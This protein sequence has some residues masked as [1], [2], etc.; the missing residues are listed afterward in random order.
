MSA[1]SDSPMCRVTLA[2]A[3]PPRNPT[4]DPLRFR[5]ADLRPGDHLRSLVDHPLRSRE[6]P[7]E[8]GLQ[9]VPPVLP[10]VPVADLFVAH[11]EAVLAHVRHETAVLVD[12]RLVDAARDIDTLGRV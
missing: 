1:P 3:R 2:T 10:V 11:V 9:T 12:Q 4:R 6:Q 8:R 7:A 5:V